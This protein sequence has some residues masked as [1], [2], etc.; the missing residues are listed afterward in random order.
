[1]NDTPNSSGSSS[2]WVIPSVDEVLANPSGI[3]DRLHAALTVRAL[4]WLDILDRDEEDPAHTPTGQRVITL[5]LQV[6]MFKVISEWLK[7]SKKT[8]STDKDDTNSPGVEAMQA[9]IVAAL[10]QMGAVDEGARSAPEA[11]QNEEN[12]ALELQRGARPKSGFARRKAARERDEDEELATLLHRARDR[13]LRQ[14]A[15]A[16][17]E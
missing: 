1:M 13:S 6:D 16:D 2:P 12:P 7:T 9:A 8:K 14:M 15:D 3:E 11:Q 4:K 17:D 5:D 10:K